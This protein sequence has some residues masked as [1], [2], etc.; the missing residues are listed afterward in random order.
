MNNHKVF[1]V[2]L[3]RITT[4]GMLDVEKIKLL[5]TDERETMVLHIVRNRGPVVKELI[6]KLKGEYLG[7]PNIRAWMGGMGYLYETKGERHTF[8]HTAA[9]KVR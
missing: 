8:I 9:H 6:P 3:R 1:N 2:L 5:T 4:R 7:Y